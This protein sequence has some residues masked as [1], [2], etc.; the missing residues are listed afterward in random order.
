MCDG[1][2]VAPSRLLMIDD[3]HKLRRKQRS[4]FIEELTELRPTM[5][6]WLAE[7]SIVLGEDLLAPGAREGRDLYEHDLEDLWGGARGQH[8]FI[9]FAQ[10][11]L[12]RRMED[13]DLIPR[14]AFTQYLRSHFLR[15][16]LRAEIARGV[17]CFRARALEHADKPRYSEWLARAERNLGETTLDALR[18][19]YVTHILLVRDAAKRQMALELEPLPIGELQDRDNSQVQ[20]A[21]EIFMHEELR[22]PYYFGTDRICVL[23]TSNIDELLA[24]AA[25]LYEGLVA[26]QILRKP[27]ILLSP[28][29]Q[30]KL[31]KDV[32]KR[33]RDF[34]PKNHTEGS[35]AQRLLDSVGSFCRDRT[36]L[37]NAPYAPGVTGVRLSAAEF[38]K[39]DVERTQQ[40]PQAKTLRRVLAE[41]VAE[42][43]LGARPSAASAGRDSGTIFYLNRTLCAHYDL[44]LQMGGWQDVSVELL[45][46]WMEKGRQPDRKM[47][48]ELA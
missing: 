1:K 44:P 21:A 2:A 10:N 8:Q 18:D 4:L 25:A 17:D 14:G 34:I 47:R 43:L 27:E 22:I 13:Q 36:F 37:P 6:V 35:R 32:A 40:P 12:D 39:L 31:I 5:A 24:I 11:I 15:D 9:S 41:C 7:R 3:V 30:E 16:E 23:A 46:E 28:R 20:G 29:E 42:N 38:L 26:K 19:L 45:V 48:L 33:K